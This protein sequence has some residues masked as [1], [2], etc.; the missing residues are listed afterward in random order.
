MQVPPHLRGLFTKELI[1]DM[2]VYGALM[3]A[4]VLTNWTLVIYVFGNGARDLATLCN[5]ADNLGPCDTVFRARSVVQMSFT[6]MILFHAYNCRHLRASLFTTEGGGRSRIFE[7]RVLI[8]SVVV[9]SLLPIP[10]LYIPT[11]NT[12]IFKQKGLTWNGG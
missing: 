4:L 3:G 1:V 5:T 6:W 2:L 12:K 8:I 10:T 9:G 7:N 11:L